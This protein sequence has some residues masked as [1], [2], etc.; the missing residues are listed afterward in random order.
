MRQIIGRLRK[1]WRDKGS[2]KNVSQKGTEKTSK[3]TA[4]RHFKS[5][6]ETLEMY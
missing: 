5:T 6:V 1:E 3:L 4:E 2:T